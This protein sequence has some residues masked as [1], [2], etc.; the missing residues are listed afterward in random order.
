VQSTQFASGAT[1]AVAT[2]FDPSTTSYNANVATPYTGPPVDANLYGA[3]PLPND[4]NASKP[5]V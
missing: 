3:P 5:T 4:P 1:Q 2:G